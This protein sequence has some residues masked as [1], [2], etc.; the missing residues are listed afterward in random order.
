VQR[1]E[2]TERALRKSQAADGANFDARFLQVWLRNAA[3]L[4]NTSKSCILS[5]D[6]RPEPTRHELL[7]LTDFFAL[8]AGGVFP[9]WITFHGRGTLWMI[10]SGHAG[11]PH[12]RVQIDR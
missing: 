10:H 5:A 12:A 6:S 11:R 8:P 7:Q 9:V 2:R 4:T 3:A 1:G